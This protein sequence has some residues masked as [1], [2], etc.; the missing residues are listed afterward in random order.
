MESKTDTTRTLP[1]P[2]RPFFHQGRR[3][4][5]DSSRRRRRRRRRLSR[6]LPPS[7]LPLDLSRIDE[8]GTI[9]HGHDRGTKAT[10]RGRRAPWPA[11]DAEMPEERT[12]V[13]WSVM[14][15]VA[16]MGSSSP[17]SIQLASTIKVW[18]EGASKRWIRSSGNR[19]IEQL[20]AYGERGAGS[21]DVRVA[22]LT[23]SPPSHK[24]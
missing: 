15:H 1:H 24:S 8:E 12:E 17:R 19:R 11:E 22:L 23:H 10:W 4:R 13:A 5:V 18:K 14:S 2:P 16:L 20:V 9:V 6:T 7:L 3:Q 21:R